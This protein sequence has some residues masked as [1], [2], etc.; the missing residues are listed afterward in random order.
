MANL[1]CKFEILRDPNFGRDPLFA[2]P[3]LSHKRR[4][5]EH[6]SRI[7]TIGQHKVLIDFDKGI[8]VVV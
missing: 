6:N 5:I 2:D 7:Q 3:G 4:Q 8:Q 1:I